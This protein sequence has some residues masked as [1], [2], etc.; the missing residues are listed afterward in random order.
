MMFW[1]TISHHLQMGGG[2]AAGSFKIL[3]HLY[4]NTQ[5]HPPENYI[6]SLS[7]PQISHLKVH[8]ETNIN[9]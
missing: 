6:L 5:C 7:E 9:I 8:T 4:Q 1:G 2:E 3:G